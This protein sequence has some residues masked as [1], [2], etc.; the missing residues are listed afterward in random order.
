MS[1][2]VNIDKKYN[3]AEKIRKLF[4]VPENRKLLAEEI[5]EIVEALNYLY[6]YG[7]GS[8]A[9]PLGASIQFLTLR[10]VNVN[11]DDATYIS[12]AL[13]GF[14]VNE[15][16]K[17]LPLIY[18]LKKVGTNSEI[19]KFQKTSYLLLQ[20]TNTAPE[21]IVKLSS[22]MLSDFIKLGSHPTGS[23]VSIINNATPRMYEHGKI[24]HIQNPNNE[25]YLFNGET[26]MYGSGVNEVSII[27]LVA[28][29]NEPVVP[30][31]EAE[32]DNLQDDIIR[33]QEFQNTFELTTDPLNVFLNTISF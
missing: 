23:V 18:V 9:Q 25:Y 2:L 3:S 15:N 33:L 11:Q 10:D 8:H 17:E 31:L 5:N 30:Q 21:H 27:D 12:Q 13:Q 4:H 14:V 22:S 32:L 7:T 29:N 26:G 1:R 24:L 20:R 19:S 6:F 28:L 16:P